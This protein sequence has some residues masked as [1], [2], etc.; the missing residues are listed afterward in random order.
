MNSLAGII[1]TSA[2]VLA[3]LWRGAG[4]PAEKAYLRALE[5]N[6]PV[7]VLPNKTGW[8]LVSF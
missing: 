6:H 7:L 5:K 1:R 8:T 4:K 3:E 2:V